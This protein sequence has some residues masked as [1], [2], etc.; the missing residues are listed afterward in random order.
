ML[1]ALSAVVITAD[2][3]LPLPVQAQASEAKDEQVVI[4]TGTAIRRIESETSLPVQV[5]DAAAIQK[6]GASS[7][8]DLIHRLPTVQGGSVESDAVGGATFGFSGVSLHNVGENRTLVLLNGRRMAQF[9]G[10]TLTGFAAAVDLNAIPISAIER[11]EILTD[12]ASSLYGSDAVAGVVNFITKSKTRDRDVSLSYYGPRG[13]AKEKGLSLTGGIGDYEADGWNLFVALAA[14]KRDE[15]NSSARDFADSAIIN[16]DQAGGRWTFFNGSPRNIPAN[17]TADNGLLKDQTVSL[18]LLGGGTCPAGSARVDL[19]CYFDYVRLIQLYP[20][21]ERKTATSSLNVKLGEESNVFVDVL[22]SRAEQTS[23]IAPVPGELSIAAGSPLF[24]QYLAPV[25]DANGDPVFVGDIVAPYRAFDLGQRV[26]EDRADFYHVTAGLEGKVFNWDYDFA[27]SQSQSDVKGNISGYPG[28]LAFANLL[29]SGVIN[30]FVG[31]GQQSA[32]GLAGLESI[33]YH[34]Y[35]DGGVSRLQSAE[36]RASRSLFNLPNGKPVMF[37]AG[38]SYFKEKFQSKPSPFAQANLADPVAGTPAAGGPGTGDQRF[39]DAAAS[40]PYGADR[41]VLGAF[42][43]VVVQPIDWLELTGSVRHDDYS[44]VGT[45]TNYKGSFKLTPVNRL[46]LRGSYGTGFHAPTVPQLNAS[47]QNYGVTSN[48][49]D[50]GPAL[51]AIATSL[52]AI[53]RPP[54]T[55]YDVFAGGNS[56]LKPEKS[57]QATFGVL[58][59][60]TPR[61][62]LGADWWW[63]GIEHAFGQIEETAAFATP[64][65]FPGAWTTFRDI[66]TGTTYIAYNQTNIN[67]GK[68][69]YSGIDF[70]L[71]GRWNTPIGRLRSQVI[72]THMLRNT[73]QLTEGGPYYQNI[74]DYSTELDNVT[75]RWGGRVATS[76]DHGP[77]SHT[78]TVNFRS[79]YKD[80][81]TP[82]DGINADGTFNGKTLDVRLNVKDYYTVDWQSSWNITKSL[83]LTVGA[84]NLLDKD[85]PLSLT[86]ANFQIGYDERYYDPRGRVFFGRVGFRF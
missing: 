55:Q 56:T 63:V 64:D 26:N 15:L 67:T 45:T 11:V 65:V 85:P 40:I 61:I 58:F 69:Y 80:I 66:G 16:F 12:G 1:F 78:V 77:W 6:T 49:Y 33:S 79:G 71:E 41:R 22:W 39:G 43:E 2:F 52:G 70:N 53:C 24:N 44:D 76:L 20:E 32:A 48:S 17:V 75:F 27:L 7:V 25:R 72:A 10:Q 57:Q 46:L 23:R 68:E 8:V 47:L 35:W 73:L 19:G 83:E 50:C 59:E 37:G 14:D 81:L 86:A 51:Q 13:G 3:T 4:V 84:L 62:S 31:P 60:A 38:L 21:R 34:G 36:V 54:Q 29:S 28:A 5:L 9:G 42:A 18:D 74:A 82:V 30:P